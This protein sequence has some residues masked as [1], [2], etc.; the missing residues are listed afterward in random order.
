MSDNIKTTELDTSSYH[1]LLKDDPIKMLI[2]IKLFDVASALIE[3]EAS[4]VMEKRETDELDDNE[5]SYLEG[6]RDVLIGL[7][8]VL[9]ASGVPITAIPNMMETVAAATASISA[10][11]A[12]G[13]VCGHCG[14]DAPEEA[15]SE[16]KDMVETLR[17]IFAAVTGAGATKH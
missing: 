8:T 13:C 16:E 3:R 6:K 2:G 4:A 12:Q 5:S 14:K 17:R 10:E 15:A 1:A 9:L 7:S 11:L